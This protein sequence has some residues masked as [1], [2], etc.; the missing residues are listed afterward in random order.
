MIRA[1]GHRT[2]MKNQTFDVKVFLHSAQLCVQQSTNWKLS[3]FCIPS[4]YY[5]NKKEGRKGER[6]SERE[7]ERGV[8][9]RMTLRE[10]K[11][12]LQENFFP[13]LNDFLQN[14]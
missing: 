13:T 7:R 9:E 11:N 12:N 5:L 1:T 6:E 14:R 3:L 4:D 2:A 8:G 10:R